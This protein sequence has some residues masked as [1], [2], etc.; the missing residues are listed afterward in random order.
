MRITTSVGGWFLLI[1]LAV[2]VFCDFLND[3]LLTCSNEFE[4]V[5]N[6]Y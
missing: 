5:F 3:S 6:A 2:I 4:I 1:R